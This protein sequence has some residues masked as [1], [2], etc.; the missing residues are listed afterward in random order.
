MT[1]TRPV[2]WAVM[3]L[4]FGIIL[5]AYGSAPLLGLGIVLG[6]FLCIFLHRIHNYKPI[7]IFILFMLLGAIRVGHSQHSHTTYPSYTTFHGIVQDTGITASGNQRL[8][9][10][11]QHPISKSTTR[12]MAYI[13]PH[14]PWA[15]LGQQII[16]TGELRPLTTPRNPSGYNQFQHLRAQKIDATMWPTSIVLGETE[17]SLIVALR[18]FRD[19]LANVYDTLL[20]PRE[21]ATI[22]SMVLGDRQD[23]DTDLANLYRTMGIF[24][25]LSI[26]GLH[27][28]I[29]MVAANKIM[30]L[31]LSERK[32]GILVL[33]LMI[34]Y[35][36]LT[37]AA[38]ST[39]RAVLMGGLMVFGKVLYRQYDMLVS[40]SWAMIILLLYEPLYLFNVG[41]QLSFGA[42]YGIGLLT[43]PI[44]RLLVKLHFKPWGKLRSSL[45][46]TI[47]AVVSTYIVFAY[48]FYEIPLYSILGSLVIM[49]TTTIIL[50]MGLL[51]GLVGLVSINVA[52]IFSGTVYYVL[53]FYEIAAFLFSSLP[54]AM[55][56]TGGGN[57]AISILGI[58]VL[59]SFVYMFHGFGPAFRHRFIFLILST[60]LL[61]SAIILTNHPQQLHITT[62]ETWGQYTVLRHKSNVFAIGNPRGSEN[63]LITYLNRHGISRACGLILTTPPRPQDAE[64]LALLAPHFHRFYLSNNMESATA[65]LTHS[66]LLEVYNLSQKHNFTMPEIVFINSKNRHQN[67]KKTTTIKT[68]EMG[69][70]GVLVQFNNISINIQTNSAHAHAVILNGT[71]KTAHA[72]YTTY[73]NGAILM[74]T[75][76]QTLRVWPFN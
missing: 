19:Q 41:F 17:R 23:M 11:G 48:H 59:A 1:V 12:V 76:G 30:N 21:A 33:I 68:Y 32:S 64:R 52:M 9:I 72:Y 46:F 71:V 22:K 45:A 58:M 39:V 67:N 56:L 8:T 70:L 75:N 54:H 40:V 47:A 15:V 53:R 13:Q 7:F 66:T 31:F 43:K 35:C 2:L 34:L 42:V 14:Q 27:V 3:F 4:V 55:V 65:S 20:P 57:I 60:V 25:I 36:L 61:S 29:L 10:R 18:R 38:V 28:T 26:S 62:L 49:P 44:E 5:G 51:V 6:S 74:R 69:Q 73:D 24:H 16:I 63:T 50:V 37:G